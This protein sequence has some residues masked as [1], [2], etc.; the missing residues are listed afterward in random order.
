MITKE[1]IRITKGDYNTDGRF[2]YYPEIRR[3]HHSWLFGDSYSWE[4]VYPVNYKTLSFSS[5]LTAISPHNDTALQAF[6]QECYNWV[7]YYDEEE[8]WKL[9]NRDEYNRVYE[10]AQTKRQQHNNNVYFK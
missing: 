2:W 8:D 4:R 1:D 7:K 3:K 9:G 10:L 5:K 6:L